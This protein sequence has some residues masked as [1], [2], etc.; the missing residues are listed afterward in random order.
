MTKNI[1]ANNALKK[2]KKKSTV[3]HT[4]AIQRDRSKRPLSMPTDQAMTERITELVHPTTLAQIDYF[5]QLGL[6]ERILT[7]PVMM[8]VVLSMIWRQ[9]GSVQELTRVVREES[10]LWAEP[11]P[12]L[13]EKAMNARLR[14]LPAE[15]F[16]RV[17]FALLPLLQQR[18]EERKRPLTPEL[19]WAR[20]RYTEVDACDGSTLDALL[21]KTGLLKDAS[22]TP[23]AGRML[24]LLDLCSHLPRRIWYESDAEAHDQRFWPQVLTAL[25]AGS[26]LIFDLGFTNFEVF[27]QLTQA[28]VTFITRAKSNLSYQVER[29]LLRSAAVHDEVVWIGGR[30][31]GQLV[32]LV[33]VLYQG[34]WYRYLSNELDAEQLPAHYLVALYWQRWRIED[35]YNTIKRLLGLAYFW[36]GA[37]NAVELQLAASWILFA[38][39]VDLTDA[40]AES[41]QKRF[42][43]LSLEMVYRS[44]PFYARA[45]HQGRATDVVDYL[46]D[47]AERFGILKRRRNRDK[48][49]VLVTLMDLTSAANP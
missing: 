23:L 46:A 12:Q 28:Q 42:A 44:L 45:Y 13:T 19:A 40:V 27:A 48:P 32:R 29:T 10:L 11:Q 41:L 18:W 14:S 22:T 35:A 36:C 1:A 20:A 39:L 3:R 38:V 15:L 43:A 21:R 8:A 26:L 6:R 25:Q 2:A 31:Q 16:W 9:I 7:L 34:K 37:Q 17:L 5:H 47:H 24:A 30:K 33:Q 4:R 49:S